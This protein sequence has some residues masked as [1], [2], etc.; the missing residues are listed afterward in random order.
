MTTALTALLGSLAVVT[1]ASPTPGAQDAAAARRAYDQAVALEADGNHPAALSLLWAAAGAAPADADILDRL[2][3]ALERIGALD[4]AIDAYERALQRRA[5]FSRAMN[6][7]VVA[8]AKAG[9]GAEAVRR[10]QG[11]V[12]AKPADSARLFTLGL[13]QSEQ[14]VDAAMRTLRQVIARKPDHALAHYN[15]ALLLKRED[16]V[17]DAIASARRA[18]SIDGRPETHL[19]L[20]SLYFQQADFAQA[21]ASLEAAIAADRRSVDAWILLGAVQ[22]ARGDLP[23]AAG[24]LR[25]AIAIR[26]ESWTAH[27]ALATVL[28]LAGD[29]DGGRRESSEAERRRIDDQRERAAVVMTAVGVSRLDAGDVDGARERFAAAV[30]AAATYAP[31]YYHLGRA[32]HRLGRIDDARAAFDKARQLNPSL[33]SP[34]DRR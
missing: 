27:A 13:A 4:A 29:A 2:G 5:D 18:A 21:A 34:L 10:A 8:L 12:A 3:E 20:G 6:G 11:W 16:R 31:A 19:A 14:D 25:R 33:V 28:T 22:K 30:A 1:L 9:R 26:P 23:R 17:E 32:L 24:A 7:L 15:L